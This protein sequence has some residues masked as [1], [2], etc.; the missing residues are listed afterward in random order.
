MPTSL[1]D[2]RWKV[3]ASEPFS[4]DVTSAMR[5]LAQERKVDFVEKEMGGSAQI[6]LGDEAVKLVVTAYD[7]VPGER[8]VA[9]LQGKGMRIPSRDKGYGPNDIDALLDD[10]VK[11]LDLIAKLNHDALDDKLQDLKAALTK[12]V[13]AYQKASKATPVEVHDDYS[14]RSMHSYIVWNPAKEPET[15]ELL[16]MLGSGSQSRIEIDVFGVKI[17]VSNDGPHGGAIHVQARKRPGSGYWDGQA[18]RTFISEMQKQ[19][20]FKTAYVRENVD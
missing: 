1:N 14:R 2:P 6:V 4:K 15:M 13:H 11:A 16:E 18:Q 8:A 10:A 17:M 7:G 19:G 9:F 20:F 5:Y 3:A 12:G